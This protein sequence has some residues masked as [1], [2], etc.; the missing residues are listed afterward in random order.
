MK[1]SASQIK[2]YCASRTKW[3]WKYI[4]WLKDDYS[5][6]N[7]AVGNLIENYLITG[8]DNIEELLKDKKIDDMEKVIEDYDNAKYN[9]IWLKFEKWVQQ[10][11]V[12][13]EILGQRFG[14]Y[15][16]NITEEWIDDVKTA[17]YLT[18]PESDAISM[19][20]WMTTMEEY[21]L[22]LWIYMKLTWRTKSRI[23]EVA[24][25][26]YKDW[27]NAHQI[28]EFI[29]TPEKDKE[30]EEKYQPIVNEMLE[31]Y[32]KFKTNGGN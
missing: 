28:L 18:K 16:D 15:I 26:K 32:N 31:L 2:T 1:F 30:M 17:K 6:D 12:E 19:F 27:R 11:K 13:W 24:K 8:K 29:L 20:S 9:A 7:F 25:H 21:W 14:W 4:L 23:L 5:E 3:A 22:Q 10:Y